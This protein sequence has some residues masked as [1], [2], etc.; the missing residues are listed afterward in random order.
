MQ[1][2]RQKLT[3]EAVTKWYNDWA[4]LRNQLQM[5]HKERSNTRK[6][7]T[8]QGL[9]H[10]I[11]FLLEMSEETIFQADKSYELL[12][13]NGQERLAFIKQAPQLYASF[14]QLDELYKETKKRCTRFYC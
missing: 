7:W 6:Q 12:P 8:E 3:N 13:L 5:A 1:V 4:I 11:Q 10:Y 9:H 2:N 14:R